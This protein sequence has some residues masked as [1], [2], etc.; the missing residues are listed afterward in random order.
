MVDEAKPPAWL[1]REGGEFLNRL[2]DAVEG[3][4]AAR[5]VTEMLGG[6]AP[7]PVMLARYVAYNEGVASAQRAIV[8]LMRASGMPVEA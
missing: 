3:C 4:Y 7:D 5:L 6:P 8:D 1:T 2:L